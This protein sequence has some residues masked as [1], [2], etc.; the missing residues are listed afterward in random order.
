MSATQQLS[1]VSLAQHGLKLNLV[2]VLPPHLTDLFRH[3]DISVL[4]KNTGTQLAHG[5]P[6]L[7]SHARNR[8]ELQR[9]RVVFHHL[10]DKY[11]RDGTW[12]MVADGGE[13]LSG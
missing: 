11:S 13:I 3:G 12:N 4:A 9:V 1:V 2:Y 6:G 10:G 7:G 5:T 8:P